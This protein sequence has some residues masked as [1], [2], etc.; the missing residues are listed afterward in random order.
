MPVDICVL[1]EPGEM[2]YEVKFDDCLPEFI[3]RIIQTG[4]LRQHAFSKYAVCRR[5]G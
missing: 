1:D 5:F 3:A 4:G 2:I